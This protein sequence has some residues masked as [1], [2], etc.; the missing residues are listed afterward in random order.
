M[1]N[2]PMIRTTE[3]RTFHRCAQQWWWS[4]RE[5]LRTRKKPA[6]ALWFGIGAHEALGKWYL[7]GFDRGPELWR[8]WDEWVG[9]EVRTIKANFTDRDREW[10]EEPAYEDAKALGIGMLRHYAQH[11]GTDPH[12]NILAIEQPFEIDLVW[13][14]DI[15]GTFVGRIDGVYYDEETGEI[16]LLEN[17]TAASIRTAHLPLDRQA[18]GYFAVATIVLRE[19]GILDRHENIAGVQYNFLRKAMPDL[20]DRDERGQYL[21]KDGNVSKRQPPP[22]FHREPVDRSP[23]EVQSILRGIT[24]DLRIM[25]AM[26]D[27]TM[28]VTKS[29]TDLCPNCPFFEMCVMHERGGTAWQEFKRSNYATEDPYA[30]HRKSSAE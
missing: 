29:V 5:G 14:D 13:Q 20:R 22:A 1:V 3:R 28:P 27:G 16:Y 19:Q 30:D 15:I 8:T 18:G 17:K 26:R 4:Y 23:R 25:N 6:D 24:D 11:Y 2:P 9:N 7:P 21:N 12:M 10:F